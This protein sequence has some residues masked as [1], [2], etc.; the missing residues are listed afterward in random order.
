MES[1]VVSHLEGMNAAIMIAVGGALVLFPRPLTSESKR[2]IRQHSRI[3]ISL[4]FV[5]SIDR[6]EEKQGALINA[7]RSWHNWVDLLRAALG[8]WLLHSGLYG[9]DS[10]GISIRDGA[11]ILLLGLAT[12]SQLYRRVSKRWALIDPCFFLSGIVLGAF[13]WPVNAVVVLLAW[14][15]GLTSQTLLVVSPVLALTGFALIYI[16]S[17]LDMVSIGICLILAAPVASIVLMGA[18]RGYVW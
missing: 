5:A 3:P 8:A 18:R 13:S 17:G 1:G 6:A 11:Y 7:L 15:A 9:P 10:M 16:T 4:P 2:R 14:I 12:L